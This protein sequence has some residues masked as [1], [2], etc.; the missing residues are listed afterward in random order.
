MIS[1]VAGETVGHWET[2]ETAPLRLP[3]MGHVAADAYGS[4]EEGAARAPPVPAIASPWVRHGAGQRCVT[5]WC[6]RGW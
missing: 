2:A 3:Y 4:R 6:V 5:W 1:S